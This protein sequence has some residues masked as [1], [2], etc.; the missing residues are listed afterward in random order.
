M[1][2]IQSVIFNGKIEV[3]AIRPIIEDFINK[4][5]PNLEVL[6]EGDAYFDICVKGD[7]Y[8]PKT[9]FNQYFIVRYNKEEDKTYLESK[10]PFG[11]T[12][13]PYLMLIQ[14][15]YSVPYK[16]KIFDAIDVNEGTSDEKTL[17]DEKRIMDLGNIEKFL[18]EKIWAK[19]S[20]ILSF[21]EKQVFKY[22]KKK[23]PSLCKNVFE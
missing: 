20:L 2:N 16:L 14:I 4:H 10:M 8:D 22:W 23:Y 18:K 1:G 9:D 19:H 3:D 11:G 6:N 5:Y 7:V 12:I 21:V 17:V 15:M 13:T